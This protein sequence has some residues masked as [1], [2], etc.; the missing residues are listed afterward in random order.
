M[1]AGTSNVDVYSKTM[2]TLE[3]CSHWQRGQQLFQ[4]CP[5]SDPC[6]VGLLGP[7]GKFGTRINLGFH[8]FQ[9]LLRWRCD[10]DDVCFLATKSHGILKKYFMIFLHISSL[11]HVD[12]VL[13]KLSQPKWWETENLKLGPDK[14]GFRSAFQGLSCCSLICYFYVLLRL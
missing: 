7:L 1:T 8:Q 9:D 14:H 3:R 11:S 12:I 5:R 4:E 10:L 2:S 6:E 13:A